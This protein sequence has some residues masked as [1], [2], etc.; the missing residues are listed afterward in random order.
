MV[1]T[2]CQGFWICS[3]SK[4]VFAMKFLTEWSLSSWRIQAPSPDRS[5]HSRTH[6][7]FTNETFTHLQIQSHFPRASLVKHSLSNPWLSQQVRLCRLGTCGW[8]LNLC[9]IESLSTTCKC[10][11]DGNWMWR[12]QGAS[13]QHSWFILTVFM[14]SHDAYS[15]RGPVCGGVCPPASLPHRQHGPDQ[16]R[17]KWSHGCLLLAQF[18]LTMFTF[19]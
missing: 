9:F 2:H 18:L 5:R 13:L 11:P 17:W 12:L 16:M 19:V 6:T 8:I 1:T 14:V 10:Q 7:F 3:F 4:L 15:M